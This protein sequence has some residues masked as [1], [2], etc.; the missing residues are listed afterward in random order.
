M[1]SSGWSDIAT[2]Y[3]LNDERLEVRDEPAQYAA[4]DAALRAGVQA[5]VSGAAGAANLAQQPKSAGGVR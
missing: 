1:P 4:A 2:L 5:I 3:H